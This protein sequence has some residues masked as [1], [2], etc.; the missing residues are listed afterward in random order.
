LFCA[1]STLNAR[2]YP[3]VD[4]FRKLDV[5]SVFFLFSFT[6]FLFLMPAFPPTVDHFRKLDIL[7]G[8]FCFAHFLLLMPAFP[9][10]WIISES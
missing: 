4:H 10:Q 2:F 6:H 8:F 7:S 3:T 1:L 9:P 5:L